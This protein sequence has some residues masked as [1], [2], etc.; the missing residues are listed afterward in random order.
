MWAGGVHRVRRT[1][2]AGEMAS[3]FKSG[4]QALPL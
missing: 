2:N 1:E 4:G 3:D